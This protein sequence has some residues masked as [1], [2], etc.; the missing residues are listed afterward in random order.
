[1][2]T[3]NPFLAPVAPLTKSQQLVAAQNRLTVD[4]RQLLSQ[5]VSTIQRNW[6]AVWANANF[7]AAEFLAQLGPTA[8]EVFRCASLLT[9]CVA[10]IDPS[11]LDP[12]YL[13]AAQPCTSNADGTVTINVVTTPGASGPSG[14]SA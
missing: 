6:S 1:M 13:S 14:P 9:A 4:G 3:P 10:A 12:K 2:S 8:A 7:T 5:V 11:L